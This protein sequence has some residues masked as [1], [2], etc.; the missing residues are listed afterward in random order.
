MRSFIVA[1]ALMTA[2]LPALA[3][4][5]SR[6]KITKEQAM[7]TALAQLKGKTLVKSSELEKE[8]GEWVWS[9]DIESGGALREIWIDATTGAVVK[10]EPESAAQEKAEK[11]KDLRVQ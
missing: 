6:V 9:F 7:K 3:K 8:K 1:L 5:T 10:N 2:A 11:I 4:K